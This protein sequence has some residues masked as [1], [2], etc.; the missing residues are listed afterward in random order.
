[1]VGQSWATAW[2]NFSNISWNSIQPGDVIY[3]SGGTDSVIYNQQ[4]TVEASGSSGGGHVKIFAGRYSPSP[5]GHSGRVILSGGGYGIHISYQDYVWVRG[6]EVR[7]SR[8]K[9]VFVDNIAD[10]CILDSLHIYDFNQD[11]G[12]SG[13]GIA[14][15][16]LITN[17]TIRNCLVQDRVYGVG[18][19][20]C[21]HVNLD[22]GNTSRRPSKLVAY[23]NFF[24]CRSQDPMAH[25]DAFQVVGCDGLILYN[26]IMMNDSVNSGTEGGGMP[27]II[28]DVNYGADNPVII[29]N[30]FAYMGGL[31]Y[32]NANYGKVFNTRHDGVGGANSSNRPSKVFVFNNT[33]VN[34]GPRDFVVQQEYGIHFLSNNIIASY[35]LPDAG[36]SNNWR[37][38]S[39]HGWFANLDG[40]DSYGGR[41][42]M[43]STRNN[44][45]WRQDSTQS[46][47]FAGSFNK[48]GGGTASFSNWSQWVAA[49]GTGLN[50]NPQFV[51]NFGHEPVQGALR[52]DLKPSSPAIDA[53]EDL[54]YLYNYFENSLGIDLP[55]MFYDI[56]G[57]PR[58]N[59]W[60]IGAFEYNNGPDL[61]PPKV[62]GAILPDSVTL[63]VNFSE[64]LDQT[65]A[66]NKN[67][68]SITNN[69]NVLNASLSGS[70]VTLQTSPHSPGSYIVTVVN[71]EDLA[72]NP[73]DPAHNTAGYEYIVLPPDTLVMFP[74]QNVEGIII[75][76]DHTPEK[77]IDGLG[78]LGGDPDS[79]WAAEPMPEELTFD[80]GT[81]RTVCRTKLSFY[82]WN[83]GRVYNYSISVST[84][85]N[86]W[87]S[88]VPQTTSAANQEW[89][90]DDFPA[91]N[92]RYV[93]VHFINNNQSNW[94]GLWEGEIWGTNITN[95]VP[96]NDGLPNKFLLYQNY[97]N[98]F[99]PSTTI[100]YSIPISAFVT[101]KIYDLLGKEIATLVN[102]AKTKG[103]YDVMFSSTS[104]SS[105]GGK[106]LN[107]PSG[108]YFYR[109]QAGSFVETKKMI[110]L[111]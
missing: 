35:C 87:V 6:L 30:N 106:V 79:R 53:G 22:G 26:N 54:T 100:R 97:P 85:H 28:S 75:E 34:N 96:T 19:S 25:N 49:G 17:T 94:A 11:G 47:L 92:A 23:N 40:S 43:D 83:D 9:G 64:A 82:N 70:K 81:N 46:G 74:V 20:D 7:W 13:F 10:N 15:I 31:W 21:V 103:N 37:S 12:G 86:N 48:P 8:D 55:A 39:N 88:I 38:G 76:P 105:S 41:L 57:N 1:M 67:N 4:L 63:V 51:N 84:N 56:N 107:L 90:I 108:I 32:P 78:A 27:F 59:N 16:G 69:I 52:P 5:S 80:L 29:F 61:T 71:V 98:P 101:I 14:L 36:G 95:V 77:T 102:E 60:D 73:V 66:E 33:L 24:H 91:V 89:T 111:R 68:Y 58:D 44:L 2:K 104:E 50:R 42:Y 45:L 93:R 109:L 3:I 62:T 72:G 110:L 18:Q 65:T 99:N